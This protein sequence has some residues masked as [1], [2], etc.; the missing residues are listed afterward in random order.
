MRSKKIPT[1]LTMQAL[2]EI[3]TGEFGGSQAAFS[4]KT[5]IDAGALFRVVAGERPATADLVGRT[6]RHLSHGPAVKLMTAYLTDAAATAGGDG[7]KIHVIAPY[8]RIKRS[9][10]D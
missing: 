10:A 5:G 7:Y 9:P 3:I 6:L 2:A 4:K 1:P 8:G